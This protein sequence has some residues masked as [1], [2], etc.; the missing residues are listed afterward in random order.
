MPGLACARGGAG[1]PPRAGGGPAGAARAPAARGGPARWPPPPP[2]W[3]NSSH[4][5][6]EALQRHGDAPLQVPGDAALLE[7]VAHPGVGQLHAIG[8]PAPLAA[9][10][11]DVVLQLLRQLGQ[12]QEDVA[13]GA[14]HGRGARHFAA[15]V[16]QLH[17][18]HQVAA[19]VA[20][21]TTRVLQ[22]QP[23]RGASIV[24]RQQPLM[25]AQNCRQEWKRLGRADPPLFPPRTGARAWQRAAYLIATLRAGAHHEAVRQKLAQRLAVQLQACTSRAQAREWAFRAAAQLGCVG[26]RLAEAIDG[27]LCTIAAR[28]LT[29]MY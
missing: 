9:G 11:G 7:A 5:V 21:V 20:L 8:A 28:T 24:T 23:A 13:R 19:G 1:P 14:H 6:P 22:P 18:V 26:C 4:L 29:C 12:V 16:D 2:R 25:W 27:P 15:R 3:A 10:G 17:G